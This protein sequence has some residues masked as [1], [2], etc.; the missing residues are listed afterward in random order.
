MKL[1]WGYAL[2]RQTRALVYT[3]ADV[4]AE[5]LIPPPNTGEVLELCR[6]VARAG[7][8]LAA[9]CEDRGLLEASER[10]LGHPI[11]SYADLLAAR[12]DTAESVA[13]AVA[14]EL[15]AATDCRFHVVH[16]ASP[17]ELSRTRTIDVS[18][19]PRKAASA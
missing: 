17:F 5:D 19:A 8:L 3:L 9:H 4:P 18:A 16:T 10:A 14:A 2:H 6:A 15:S 7:G 13:I 11:A 12:P 1:F